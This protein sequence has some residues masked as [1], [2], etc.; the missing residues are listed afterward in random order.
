M[1]NEGEHS[2][3]PNSYSLKTEGR[4]SYM[5]AFLLYTGHVFEIFI[6]HVAPCHMVS[7]CQYFC[8]VVNPFNFYVQFI[9]RTWDTVCAGHICFPYED[10]G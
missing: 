9:K 8:F 3:L 6:F 5:N 7:L 2:P 10:D 4:N 1:W